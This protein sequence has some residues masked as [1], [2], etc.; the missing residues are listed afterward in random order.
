MIKIYIDFRVA[1]CWSK[2]HTLGV[3]YISLVTWQWCGSSSTIQAL[4]HFRSRAPGLVAGK[5]SFSWMK[6]MT[7]VNPRKR[8]WQTREG[9]SVFLHYSSN[10]SE[11]LLNH[12][13]FTLLSP[14]NW[15]SRRVTLRWNWRRCSQH[16]SVLPSGRLP[17]P[18][19]PRS[20][21]LP[22]CSG[23]CSPPPSSPSWPTSCWTWEGKGTQGLP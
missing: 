11:G 10:Q 14:E 23:S 22:S 8:S 18:R 9:Y 6:D 1:E 5:R 20:S 19:R 13:H 16:L 21:W 15:G 4:Q 3:F 17:E 7:S 12:A 2:T